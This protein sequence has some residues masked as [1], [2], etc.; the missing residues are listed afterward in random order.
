MKTVFAFLIGFLGLLTVTYAQSDSMFQYERTI[1]GDIKMFSTDPLGNL[2]LVDRRD[3]VK[4]LNA[5]GDSLAVYNDVRRLGPLRG[6]DVS[7]PLQPILFYGDGVRFVVLDRFLN[8]VTRIDMQSIDI[9]QLQAWVR[10]YDNQLWL[11]DPLAYALKKV[12]LTGKV[13][14]STPDFR[15]ILGRPFTPIQLFDQDRNLYMYEPN[16]GV[17][18]FDYFG[19]L[20]NGIQ[21]YDWQDLQVDG[22]FIYGRKSDTLYR[23]EI[24][25]TY[26][27][28]WTLPAE[29]RQAKQYHIRGKKI[30]ALFQ[31][32]QPDR[33][34]IY[35]I[36]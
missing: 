13:Q 16:H 4:K 7:N 25:S 9:L 17:Y 22:G 5:Q 31:T 2:Y 21:L 28:E 3:Q 36:R 23:Y 1:S 30:Y 27:D 26:Y 10:S 11:F 15:L 12:D 8:P 34:R 33:I 32:G 6:M 14:W 35:S 24:K 29:L 18:V 20:K 19:N